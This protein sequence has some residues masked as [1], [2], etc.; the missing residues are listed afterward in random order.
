[1]V[2]SRGPGMRDLPVRTR[3]ESARQRVTRRPRSTERAMTPLLQID[4]LRTEFDTE[5]GT[6][7]AVDGVN[8][9]I[10]PGE[11]LGLV[12][13]SGCGKTVTGLSILSLIQP[14][15]RVAA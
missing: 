5:D 15:G 14:P 2:G 11:I 7:R 6:I 1:M 3:L 12:G 4:S 13:E 10:M 8:L 9:S